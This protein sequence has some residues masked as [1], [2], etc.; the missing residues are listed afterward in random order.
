MEVPLP[1]SVAQLG[2]D[3]DGCDRGEEVCVGTAL[4]HCVGPALSSV[5]DL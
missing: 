4:S 3:V 5:D 2:E 1:W